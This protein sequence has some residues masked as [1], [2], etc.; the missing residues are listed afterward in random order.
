MTDLESLQRL[1]AVLVREGYIDAYQLFGPVNT[2]FASLR[3]HLDPLPS[4][5]RGLVQLFLLAEAVA[6]DVLAPALTPGDLAALVRLRLLVEEAAGLRS[7]GLRLLPIAG[8]L[9]F[10]PAVTPAGWVGGDQL[11]L[12]L[13]AMPARSG[14]SID[15][16]ASTG[17]LAIHLASRGA[18]VIAVESNAELARAAALNIAMA[19]LDRRVEV[20]DG[21]LWLAAP[22]QRFNRVTAIPPT[23]PGPPHLMAARHGGGDGFLVVRRILGALP[24]ILSHDG[25]ASLAGVCLGNRSGPFGAPEL[26]RLA[27]DHDLSVV[28]TVPS[29]QS[30]QPGEKG[31]ERLVLL[32][33]AATG[34]DAEVMRDQLA[35]HLRQQHSDQLYYYFITASR[36][37]EGLR[38]T[39]HYREPGGFWFR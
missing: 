39:S 11:A 10:V 35:E 2:R 1:P 15:L 5:L 17:A 3:R 4:P 30:I 24:R 27:R 16:C 33:A 26:G 34:V 8:R 38:H 12:L 31:F 29:R 37:G 21:D 9:V 36:G 25:I 7:N 22:G 6:P 13:R 14:L 19:Q 18:H 28:W 23:L 20:R 32:C